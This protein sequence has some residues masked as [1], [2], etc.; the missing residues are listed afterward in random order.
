MACWIFSSIFH[1][2][3]FVLTERLDYFGAGASVLYGLYFA[4]ITNIPSLS[5][6]DTTDCPDMDPILSCLLRRSRL[7]STIHLMGLHLQYDGKRGG[8]IVSECAMDI[9]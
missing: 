9:L 5:V 6:R 4:P 2:R 1:T 3:D 8:W 7:L